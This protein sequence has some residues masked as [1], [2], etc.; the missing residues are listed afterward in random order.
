MKKAY[1]E[2][3]DLSAHGF[4]KTPNLWFDWESGKGKPF[5]YYKYK[6]IRKALSLY[7]VVVVVVSG[8]LE[9]NEPNFNL[10]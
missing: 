1:F 2:R 8:I 7:R 3:I 5:A 6:S 10:F 4:Y 9:E